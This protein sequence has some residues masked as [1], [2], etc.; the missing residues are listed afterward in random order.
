MAYSFGRIVV[1]H[2]RSDNSGRTTP[3]VPLC[4]NSP[5]VEQVLSL[6]AAWKVSGF[7]LEFFTTIE[8]SNRLREKGRRKVI[9]R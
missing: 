7:V 6:C 9:S 5:I 4:E 8:E 2:Y 1:T 3:H